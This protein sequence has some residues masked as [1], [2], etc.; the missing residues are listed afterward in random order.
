ML[1]GDERTFLQDLGSKNGT[2]MAG[3][4]V[5]RTRL[6]PGDTFTLGTHYRCRYSESSDG[7]AA[8][9]RPA[10]DGRVNADTTA[11]VHRRGQGGL[12]DFP[13]DDRE[14]FIGSSPAAEELLK[15]VRRVANTRVN[16][17]VSGESGSG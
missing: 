2:F 3:R 14:L 7:A 13:A 4:R 5:S 16:V 10:E 6:K 9:P 17:L 1:D 11:E 8:R 15:R 12:P